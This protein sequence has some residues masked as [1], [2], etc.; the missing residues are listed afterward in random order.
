[1][2]RL[3]GEIK[4]ALSVKTE[5]CFKHRDFLGF[6]PPTHPG[7]EPYLL[8]RCLHEHVNRNIYILNLNT[9]T[10]GEQKNKMYIQSYALMLGFGLILKFWIYCTS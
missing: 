1:M 3:A 2:H 10:C 7:K 5:H 9:W 4:K 6:F 8:A